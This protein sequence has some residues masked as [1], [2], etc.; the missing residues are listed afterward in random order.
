MQKIKLI[1]LMILLS[2]FFTSQVSAFKQ[3]DLGKPKSINKCNKCDLIQAGL[4]MAKLN[5]ANVSDADLRETDLKDVNLD[6]AILCN[7]IMPDGK[8]NNSDCK[9]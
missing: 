4:I 3:E 5:G 1:P 8:A 2:G 6:G 9:K 7:T